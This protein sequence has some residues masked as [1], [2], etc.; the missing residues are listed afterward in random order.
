MSFTRNITE[1]FDNENA[2]ILL[3]RQATNKM[4]YLA[5]LF[6]LEELEKQLEIII[7]VGLSLHSI[8]TNNNQEKCRL[9]IPRRRASP[10]L[11]EQAEVI[12]CAVHKKEASN[13][14]A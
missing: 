12:K 11:K 2:D 7:I 1:K 9:R 6:I 5:F 10:M 13:F 14:C 3:S 4:R 8:N